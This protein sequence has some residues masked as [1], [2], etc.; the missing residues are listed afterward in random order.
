MYK[1]AGDAAGFA[2]HERILEWWGRR[3]FQRTD[4]LFCVLVRLDILP[5]WSKKCVV[6]ASCVFS[7]CGG[8]QLMRNRPE[9]SRFQRDS[10]VIPKKKVS[11]GLT[12][13]WWHA[14][15]RTVSGPKCL[16]WAPL[17]SGKWSKLPWC[18]LSITIQDCGGKGE[19]GKY[20][21]RIDG[22]PSVKWLATHWVFWL[23]FGGSFSYLKQRCALEAS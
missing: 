8:C 23:S 18:T 12:L 7:T 14:A 15:M 17:S 6:R 20:A 10:H 19:C 5:S 9:M 16:L 13:F 21:K 22:K 1:K 3:D 11:Y 2:D 4:S